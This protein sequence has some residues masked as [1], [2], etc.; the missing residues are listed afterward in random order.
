MNDIA[1]P[2]LDSQHRKIAG[3]CFVYRVALHPGSFGR[4][5]VA[6]R[7]QSLRVAHGMPRMI[8]RRTDVIRPRQSFD[9]GM[10]MLQAVVTTNTASIPFPLAFQILKLA[11]DGYL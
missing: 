2:Y 9:Q 10:Q 8:H 7:M 6:E 3:S 5:E 11:L 1:F 4:D